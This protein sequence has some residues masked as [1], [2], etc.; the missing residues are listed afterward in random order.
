MDGSGSPPSSAIGATPVI[1]T[2]VAIMSLRQTAR[3]TRDS[4]S[5]VGEVEGAGVAGVAEEMVV[6][7]VA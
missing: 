4:G 2:S 7:A 5:E 3:E 1:S 6:V